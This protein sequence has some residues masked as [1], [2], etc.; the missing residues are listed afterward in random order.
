[1]KTSKL[2][3]QLQLIPDGESTRTVSLEGEELELKDDIKLQKGKLDVVFYK[4]DH[5]VQTRFTVEADAELICD[6]SVRPFTKSVEGSYTVH[7]EPDPEEETETEKEAI[8]RIP[9]EELTLSIEKEVRDTILLNLP[10]RKIHPDLLDEDGV[11]LEFETKK[12]GDHPQEE[13]IDPRWEKL[14]KLKKN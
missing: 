4:T 13:T 6:R 8:R 3:F 5:F 9:P 7:F 2:I 10:T 11:P 12:F 1:M 14:K